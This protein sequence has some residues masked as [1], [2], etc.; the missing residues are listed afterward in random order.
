MIRRLPFAALA[1]ALLVPAARADLKLHPLFSD[2]MVLQRDANCPVW[3]TA[4]PG[5]KISVILKGRATI[6]IGGAWP[7][8]TVAGRSNY[9]SPKCIRRPTRRGC[10]H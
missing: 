7:T 4:D 1:A 3:G 10:T 8:R 5:E 6:D 9:P 2:G